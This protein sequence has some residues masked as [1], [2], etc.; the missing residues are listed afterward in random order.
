[1]KRLLMV[2]AL[3]AAPLWAVEP[4]EVL[5]DPVLEERARELSQGLRCPV[6]RNE[7]I[8]ESNATLAKELRIVL[9][10]RLVAGDTDEEAV[11][12]M[13]ARYGEF[14]LLRPDT[15]GANI[16]L[17]LAAP[18]FLLIALGIGWTAIRSKR[19]TPTALTEAEQAE[20]DKIL[21]S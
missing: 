15:S 4:D 8:D 7:S 2:F 14:V 11:D 3:L 12:F 16:V 9:R 1:M 17:W 21:R 6:C 5:D 20:L 10:E 18:A 19:S 13:V